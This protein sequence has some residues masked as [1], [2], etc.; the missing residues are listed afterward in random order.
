M[1][2]GAMDG[3][4]GAVKRS[5]IKVHRA[6]QSQAHEL[7]YLMDAV[8]PQDHGWRHHHSGVIS[9]HAAAVPQ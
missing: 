3:G 8:L 2:G 5:W 1:D 4:A 7:L 6:T 9:S